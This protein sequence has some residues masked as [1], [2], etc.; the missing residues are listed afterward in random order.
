MFVK[1]IE[2]KLKKIIDENLNMPT[3]INPDNELKKY[4]IDSITFIKIIVCIENEFKIEFDD[5]NLDS[6]RLS[7]LNNLIEYVEGKI[8]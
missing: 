4:G 7:T 3:E 2:I 1:E 5:E 6:N 8:G